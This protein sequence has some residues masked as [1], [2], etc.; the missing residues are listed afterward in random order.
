VGGGKCVVVVDDGI[1]GVS[2][3]GAARD[4]EKTLAGASHENCFCHTWTVK[5]D[6]G[7]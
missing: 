3:V 4:D 6:R 2:V 1:V 7:V 5:G